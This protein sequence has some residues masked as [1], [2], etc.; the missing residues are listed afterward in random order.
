MTLAA[1]L[2]ISLSGIRT[3]SLQLE[4]TASNISNASSEGYTTKKIN[5]TSASLGTIGG[6]VLVSG[7][8]RSEN[9]ALFTTLSSATSDASYRATQDNYLQQVMDIWGTSSSDNPA[10]S[11]VVADFINSW[12]TLSAT[13][14]SQIN[15]RQVVSD[16]EALCD[17]VQRLAGEVES[18]DRQCANDITSTIADLNSYLQQVQDF[19][20]KIAQAENSGFSSGDQK[21]QRDQIVLKIAALMDVTV[22]ERPNGQIALYSDSGYQLVDGATVRDFSYNGTIVTN[23]S[24]TSL[25]LNSALTGGKLQALIDFRADTSTS[26]TATNISASL[27]DANTYLSQIQTLNATIVSEQ[28][29]GNDTTALEATRATTVTN[30]SSIIAVNTTANADGSIDITTDDGT[31]LLNATSMAVLSFNGDHVTDAAHPSVALEDSLTGGSL[32][33]QIHSYSGT[34]SVSTD[35]ATS[36]IQKLRDQL[37]EIVR[38]FT[39]TVTTATSGLGSFASA[40][41]NATT[42]AGELASS[43]FVGTSRTTF[44]VNSALTDGTSALK[45]MAASDVSDALLDSTRSFSADGL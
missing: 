5:T 36:V 40:Y 37:D 34:A 23:S 7:F 31:V 44:A 22:M 39:D 42:G 45:S 24:N 26:V 33:V 19:N 8:S 18:L 28:A 3:T 17:E 13:P 25:S 41:N 1:A 9:A 21:D 29:L 11:S 20:I 43:F 32:E 30:L 27:T 10:I 4:Q 6:G 2:N 12:N 15:Q 38:A 14:E 35:Q 16:A